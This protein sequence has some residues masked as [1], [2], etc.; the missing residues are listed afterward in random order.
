MREAESV[1]DE[2]LLRL[3]DLFILR[4]QDSAAER[5]V[6][7]R[8]KKTENVR[9][10]EWL[11]KYYEDRNNPT[12]ALEQAESIF[13]KQPYLGNYQE[14][15]DLAGQLGGR[16]IAD[17]TRSSPSACRRSTM[18]SIANPASASSRSSCARRTQIRE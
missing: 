12:A 13:R 6:Q 18:L 14:V 15:R 9:I 10:I 3:A 8:I 7:E 5:V 4:G 16:L 2:A 17:V 1:G 11:K